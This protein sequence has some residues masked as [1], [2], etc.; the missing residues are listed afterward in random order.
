[1]VKNPKET[2]SF[3]KLRVYQDSLNFS[4]KIYKLTK[5]FAKQIF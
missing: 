3:E 4:K 1:M 2:F 5:K